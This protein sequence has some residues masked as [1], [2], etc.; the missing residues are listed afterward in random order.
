MTFDN[1]K[2]LPLIDQRAREISRLRAEVARLR[3]VLETIFRARVIRWS[4]DLQPSCNWC[5][6][7]GLVG[8]PDSPIEHNVDCPFAALTDTAEKE[9]R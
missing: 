2:N 7:R 4:H 3:E 5:L 6:A 1:E 8:Q 9:E